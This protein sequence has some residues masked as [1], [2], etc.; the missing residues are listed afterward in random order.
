ML[1][2]FYVTTLVK[3]STYAKSLLRDYLGEGFKVC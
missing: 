3:D 2:V 1:R